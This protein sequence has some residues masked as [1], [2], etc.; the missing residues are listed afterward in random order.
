[1]SDQ[2][3]PNSEPVRLFAGGHDGKLTTPVGEHLPVRVF[4]RGPDLLLLVPLLDAGE[5]LSSDA[6]E[7]VLLEYVSERGLLRFHGQAVLQD[8][9][10][11]R[12]DVL[13]QPE[14]VQRREF[15]RVDTAQPVVV[16]TEDGRE[17]VGTHAID[18]SGG[19]MLLSGADKLEPGAEVRFSLNLRAEEAPVEGRARAVRAAGEGRIGLVF[20]QISPADRQRL[21]HFVFECQRAALARTRRKAR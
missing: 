11:V 15:V 19:G 12:F 1:M 13:G 3:Q 21:I 14:V 18:I 20:E 5:E 8:R 9:D 6:I 4:G 2:P 17:P 10:L 7:P 16:A